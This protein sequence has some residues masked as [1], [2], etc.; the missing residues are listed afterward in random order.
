MAKKNIT[1]TPEADSSLGLVLYTD[2]GCNPNPGGNCG[3]GIHGYTYAISSITDKATKKIDLPTTD[4]YKNGNGLP[5]GVMQVTP[6]VYFDQWGP[7]YGDTSNNIAELNGAIHGMHVVSEHQPTRVKMVLDSE[8]VLKGITQWAAK[9]EKNGWINS[10]GKPVSNQSEWVQ[11]MQSVRDHEANGVTF[12]WEW[13]KGHAD[14]IGNQRADR[15]ATRGVHLS[16]MN[17]PHDIAETYDA[18]EYW[19]PDNRP[20]RFY[21]HTC[22]Y[23]FSH[24]G[25]QPTSRDGRYVYYCGVHDKQTV[26]QGTPKLTANRRKNELFGKSS[27]DLRYS[28]LFTKQPDPVLETLRVHQDNISKNNYSNV[29]IADL[30]ACFSQENYNTVSRYGT[31]Y[32]TTVPMFNDIYTLEEEMLTF[33][34]SPP[35]LALRAM[36]KIVLLERVLESYLGTAAPEERLDVVVTDVTAQLY[37][38]ETKKSK[39]VQKIKK[40]IVPGLKTIKLPVRYNTTGVEQT[41]EIA[42]TLGLHTPERN[43]MAALADQGVKVSVVTWRDAINSFRHAFVLEAGDDSSIYAAVDANSVFIKP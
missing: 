14:N 32:L 22:W 16:S 42:F 10:T 29:V 25:L 8:Y 1:V 20:S 7:L 4:G 31:D 18:K 15:N 30:S 19:K 41:M 28:V 39:T 17:E 21:G 12:S 38:V 40:H 5:V 23:F 27:G 43:T 2:G 9:W 37:D 36:D 26:K 24:I 11:L 13:T 6:T 3:W 35:R 33:E 34:A